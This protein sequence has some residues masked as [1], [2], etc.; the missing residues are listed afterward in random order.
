M[1]RRQ[2]LLGSAATVAAT[3]LPT[4]AFEH[5][6]MPFADP[7]PEMTAAMKFFWDAKREMMCVTG[8]SFKDLYITEDWK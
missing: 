3:T 6:I 1:N 7:W 2:V 4:V 8:I 5:G